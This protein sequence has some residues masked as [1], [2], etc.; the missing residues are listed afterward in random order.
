[1]IRKVIPTPFFQHVRFRVTDV[2]LQQIPHLKLF[3]TI[4]S[5]KMVSP[6]HQKVGGKL[7]DTNMATGPV[8]V[9]HVRH[10]QWPGGD[11][12]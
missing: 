4:R 1:M 11:T 12:A 9:Q 3:T 5:F 6:N 10:E 2:I 8:R 7:M